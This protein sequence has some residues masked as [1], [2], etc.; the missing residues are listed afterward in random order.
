MQTNIPAN[1]IGRVRGVHGQIVEVEYEKSENLPKFYEIL[2]SPENP[3]VCLEVY[4]YSDRNSVYCLSISGK[5][6]LKRDLP[7]V[8]T[9]RS[10]TIRA[11]TNLLGRLINI[12]GE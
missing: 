9:G 5:H 7:I 8:T 4:A 10:L 11:S 1:F 3:K 2:V 6:I 12:Y